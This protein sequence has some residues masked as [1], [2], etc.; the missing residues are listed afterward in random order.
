MEVE[1]RVR[2]GCLEI[3]PVALDAVVEKQGRLTVVRPKKRIATL[4]TK[5]VQQTIARLRGDEE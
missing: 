5:D 1:I 3:E 2:G 4:T